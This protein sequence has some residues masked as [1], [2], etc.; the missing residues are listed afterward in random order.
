MPRFLLR[1]AKSHTRQLQGYNQV[2]QYG[3]NALLY[4][5]RQNLFQGSQSINEGRKIASHKSVCL[6]KRLPVTKRKMQQQCSVQVGQ[7]EVKSLLFT[8][9]ALNP[10][11][12]EVTHSSAEPWQLHMLRQMSADLR[13]QP[14]PVRQAER[15]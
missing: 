5:P 15:F 2:N 6:A 10:D 7:N 11:K 12:A 4:V 9:G 14:V 8:P 3:G 1:L 13:Q